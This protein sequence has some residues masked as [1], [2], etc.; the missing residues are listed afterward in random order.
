MVS[1]LDEFEAVY[2]V[3]I[4]VL[5]EWSGRLDNDEDR[6]RLEVSELNAAVHDFTYQDWWYPSTDGG[7][8][9]LVIVDDA[10]QPGSWRERGSWAAG[11]AGGGS[12][13]SG[14][15]FFVFGGVDQEVNL[16]A[17]ATLDATVSYGALIRDAVTRRWVQQGGPA[18]VTF[19]NSDTEDTVVSAPV[20]GLYTLALV[21]TSENGV[22]RTGRVSVVFRDSYETWAGRRFAEA[23]PE[24]ARRDSDPDGDGFINLVEFGLG[25]DPSVP[26]SAALLTPFLTP[27]GEN[28][29]VYFLP[30]LSDQYRIVPEVSSDLLLWQS[31][32]GHVEE[33]VIWTMPDGKWIQAQ[34]LFP[35]DGTTSR[36]MRLRVESD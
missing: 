31:G 32:S 9:S 16:P 29:M 15:G 28:A 12:P 36:F 19:G 7:G 24:S 8:F 10:L 30:Y 33:S 4:T 17:T 18:P 20:G 2:G 25:L 5:G 6:L 1:D 21:A 35:Y 3:G 34:D 22:S 26:D 13:G 27:T 11:V 23:G 14:S